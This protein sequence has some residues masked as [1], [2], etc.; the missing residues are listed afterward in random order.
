[1][2]SVRRSVSTCS[3]SSGI[4][5]P[6]TIRSTFS[7][8]MAPVRPCAGTSPPRRF[9]LILRIQKVCG[10]FTFSRIHTGTKTA[11][12]ITTVL[13]SRP[14]QSTAQ[15]GFRNMC[16]TGFAPLPV[17]APYFLT[18]QMNKQARISH[19][20]DHTAPA[21]RPSFEGRPAFL[22]EWAPA[23]LHWG[24]RD[25]VLIAIQGQECEVTLCPI[26]ILPRSRSSGPALWIS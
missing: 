2:G 22:R 20:A 1:M 23:A 15:S 25:M 16:G 5:G 9:C 11:R 21:G 13:R 3:G 14:A 12:Q 19:A 24:L 26:S 4:W 8:R 7:I 10:G 18:S 17:R 6:R